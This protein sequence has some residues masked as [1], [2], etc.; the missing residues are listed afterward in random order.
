LL[1]RFHAFQSEGLANLLSRSTTIETARAS[2]E[3]AVQGQG[4]PL[5]VAHGSM[6]GYDQG[7]T[8]LYFL[9]DDGV[10]LIA[11]SRFGYLRSSQPSDSSTAAQAEAYADLL[12]AVEIEKVWVVGL[13][14]GGLSALHFALHFPQRCRGLIMISAI[15]GRISQPT[16]LRFMVEHVLTNDFLGWYLA[17]HHPRLV[18]RSTG[19]DYALVENDPALKSAFLS[20]AWP[21]LA[22]RRRAGMLNDFQQADQQ[23]DG[24]LQPLTVPLLVIHGTADP[25][26]PFASAQKLLADNPQAQKLIF[27]DGGHLSFLLYQEQ[28]KT[29]IM[30]FLG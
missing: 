5:L 18:A 1:N 15:S 30:N 28:T 2:I 22:S 7:L 20:L 27:A 14:A 10:K 6:G 13:S 4:L 11:P 12:D 16:G 19:D 24:Q 3:Y 26:S 8:A 9:R 25:L 23:T 29:A 17:T 21:A